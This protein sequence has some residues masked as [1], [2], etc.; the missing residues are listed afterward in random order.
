M[1]K[2]FVAMYALYVCICVLK[3]EASPLG[4]FL[5]FM[6][7]S[8]QRSRILKLK[9]TSTYF[10]PS[11]SVRISFC[12]KGKEGCVTSLHNHSKCSLQGLRPNA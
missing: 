3:R 12:T 5:C 10:L 1:F 9:S 8:K 4:G 2:L 6:I 11:L 7:F